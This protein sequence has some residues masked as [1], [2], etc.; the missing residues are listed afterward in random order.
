TASLNR[1]KFGVCFADLDGDGKPDLYQGNGHVHD[2][3]HDF[4]DLATFEQVD[5]AFL[6][7]GG[8]RFR[9][10]LPS[11]GAFPNVWSVTR[12]VAAGDFN[13]DG[14]IDLLINSLGRPARLLENRTA[15]HGHWVGL[16][17][18]G[19]RSNRDAIGTR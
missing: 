17:L 9:E 13:D 15:P 10:V 16:R 11:T 7:I 2:N 8:G 19:R 3:V 18:I 1:L 12:A 6:N 14:A 5:Q 4:N